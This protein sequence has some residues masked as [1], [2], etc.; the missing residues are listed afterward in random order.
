MLRY[1]KGCIG[2]GVL[3]GK[4][5]SFQLQ[6]FS[7]ADWAPC[8]NSRKFVIGFCIFLG[9]SL[10]AWKAKKQTIVS[11]SSAK[12]EYRALAATTSEIFWFN[13]DLL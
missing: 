12:A 6:A 2:K 4:T 5:S 9:D 3:L 8:S 1:L 13:N 7:D 10:V 11:R